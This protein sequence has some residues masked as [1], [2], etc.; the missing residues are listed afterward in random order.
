M[1]FNENTS[2]FRL[3]LDLDGT[4]VDFEKG[5]KKA[6]ME[7]DPE[8]VKATGYNLDE[9]VSVFEDKLIRHYIHKG[10][11]PKKAKGKAKGRFWRPV[12][13]NIDFWINLDWMPDGQELF[14]YCWELKKDKK[15]SELSILSSPSSDR[16]CIPGKKAWI[17]KH[18]LTNHFDNLIF[19]K[20]KHEYSTGPYDIL[21]D[22]THKKIKAW[23]EIGKGSPVFHTATPDSIQQIKDIMEKNHEQSSNDSGSI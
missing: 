15:I 5:Y 17:E 19:Y 20:D 14:N 16:V 7:T 13:G 8:I 9:P 11:E 6:L 2:K 23:S 3:F 10:A 22:D 21:V 1:I 12:E 18:G 4:I